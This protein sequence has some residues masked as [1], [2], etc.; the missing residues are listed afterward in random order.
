MKLSQK[1]K[2]DIINFDTVVCKK[3]IDSHSNDIL[4]TFS[5]NS[6]SQGF[7]DNSKF[8]DDK[9]IKKEIPNNND[10]N[11]NNNK[12]DSNF[13][14]NIFYNQNPKNNMELTDNSIQ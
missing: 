11:N 2:K 12:N 4:E 3:Y 14:N 1:N 10:L 6:L 5:N 7:F 9:N 8:K 13:F